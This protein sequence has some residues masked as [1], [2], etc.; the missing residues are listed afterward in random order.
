M[1]NLASNIDLLIPIIKEK[2]YQIG[3]FVMG[4][5]VYRNIWSPKEKDSLHTEMEPTNVMDK[6]S[7]AVKDKTTTVGHLPKGKT[8]RFCKTIFYF[9]KLE[10]TNCEVEITSPKAVNLGDGLGM[11]IPCKLIFRGQSQFVDILEKVLCKHK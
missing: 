3:S 4:Y 8:G 7:V 10:N 5:H 11:R 1:E 6:F 9:L 2:E